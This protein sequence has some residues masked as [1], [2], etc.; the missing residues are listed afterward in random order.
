MRKLL[1]LIVKFVKFGVV[2][3][4]GMIV[5]YGVLF[6]MK[7]VV[8]LPALWANAISFT[9]AATSNYFLNRIWTFR[10][11]EKQVGVEYGKFLAVSLI[12][13]GISTL[14]LFLLGRL[15]PEWNADWRFYILKFFAIVI[16]TIWNFFG[17]LLFTFRKR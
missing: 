17:N 13:L 15:L 4:S 5:D 7:E 10:S 6:L 8:G 9:V 12:G 2:G 16:T 1:P 3:F 14:S 11:N